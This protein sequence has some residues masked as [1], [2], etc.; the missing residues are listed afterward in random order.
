MCNTPAK[1]AI[2]GKREAITLITKRDIPKKKWMSLGTGVK[3][4]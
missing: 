1:V 3:K 4:S 2:T